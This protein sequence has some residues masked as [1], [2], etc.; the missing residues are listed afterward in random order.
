MDENTT[1]KDTLLRKHTNIINKHNYVDY[2][3]IKHFFHK[4]RSIIYK[5]TYVDYK[6]IL[7]EPNNS[8]IT[9]KG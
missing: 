8:G 1:T 4:Y 9:Q 6:S 2:K 7:C 3:N 5:Y